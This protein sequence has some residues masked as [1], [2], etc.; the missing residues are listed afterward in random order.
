MVHV[1]KSAP[2]FDLKYHTFQVSPF[3]KDIIE[4]VWTISNEGGN[5]EY[6]PT[7]K[8]F[9]PGY[10]ELIIHT[11]KGRYI[12][13]KANGWA[14]YPEAFLGGI[15]KT[16]HEWRALADSSMLG[17]RFKPEGLMRLL[18]IPLSLIGDLFLDVRD[19]KSAVLDNLQEIMQRK[20]PME[21]RLFSMEAYLYELLKQRQQSLNLVQLALPILRECQECTV[22]DL[23]QRLHICERQLQRYFEQEYGYTPKTY[24][25][26]SRLARFHQNAIKR[27]QVSMQELSWSLGYSDTSHLSKDFK[28]FFGVSPGAYFQNLSI[29]SMN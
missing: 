14:P 23:A 13:R 29:R 4:E 27:R 9:S 26:M 21:Q 10:V 1:I 2:V 5:T 12:E 17:I 11:D 6:S 16:A 22:A 15:T 25:K 7:Q 28:S 19:L 20:Q 18:D 24:Q 3:L 8:C